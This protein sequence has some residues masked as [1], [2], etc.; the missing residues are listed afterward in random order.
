MT[1]EP[2]QPRPPGLVRLRGI[3]KRYGTGTLALDGFDLDID[4]REFIT[5]VGPSGCGKSTILRLIAGLGEASAGTVTTVAADSGSG[6]HPASPATNGAGTRLDM[7]FQEATLMPWRRVRRNVELPLE[8]RGVGRRTRRDE[9]MSMLEL[10]NLEAVANQY[11]RQL[12]GGMKMRVAIARALVSKPELLLMDEPF[13]AVDE[14]TRQKLQED[15]LDLWRSMDLTV[16]FVTHNVYEAVFLSQRIAVMTTNPGR[17]Y[18]LIANPAPYPRSQ[19]FRA[20][21]DFSTL[22]TRTAATLKEGE[23]WRS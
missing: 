1:A 2:M 19:A 13:G 16:V 18:R 7:V 12:S 5:L 14:L 20:S 3:S 8:M 23:A 6:T 15:L 4:R 9:A 22:A 11:P 17:V 10:V 21:T